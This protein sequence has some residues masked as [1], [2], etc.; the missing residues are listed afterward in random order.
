MTWDTIFKAG[1][2]TSSSGIRRTWDTKD[3]DSL[4][5]NFSGNVPVLML[6]PEDQEKAAS[7]GKIAE[8]KRIEDS[9][10]QSTPMSRKSLKKP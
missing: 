2:H 3:L 4:V 6:H 7:F 10:W 9:W 5:D 8:L 1:T